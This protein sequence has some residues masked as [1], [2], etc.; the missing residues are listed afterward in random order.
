MTTKRG[1]RRTFTPP[2]GV[3]LA[4]FALIALWLFFPFLIREN[5]G[6]DALP[7]MVA[8][9]MA[10]EHPD[11]VYASE[12][13]DLYRL[14]PTFAARSCELA[15]PG[16]DCANLTVA[17]VAT[18]FALPLAV[19]LAPL[20]GDWGTFVLRLVGAAAL[21]GGMW[22][23][24]TRLAHR[25]RRAGH[26]MVVT[27]LLLTPFAMAPIALGQTSQLLFLSACLGI[28]RAE[29]RRGALA[30]ALWVATVAIKIFPAT[31]ALVLLW[32]RRWRFLVWSIAWT[33]ILA[34]LTLLVAP[35]SVWA[36]FV[37]ASTQLAGQT[38]WN[39]YNGSIDALVHN[40]ASPITDS[41]AGSLAL[42]L[43]RILGAG[44][45]AVWA[46][47][48]ADED[49]QWAYALLLTLLLVPLV[50]WHYLWIAVA[51]VA[52][53]LAGRVELDDRTLGVL[54]VLAAITIPI[55]ILTG[56]DGYVPVA[57]GLFLIAAVALVPVLVTGWSVRG[58]RRATATPDVT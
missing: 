46:A 47:R 56:R 11:D 53:A 55:S 13:G 20:G 38:N 7:Y 25:T 5:L 37:K 57:Q 21:S 40:L 48:H 42:L 39:L 18:P 2:D 44:A 33:A 23:L 54:P 3:R 9:Q 14:R 36:D 4:Y 31:L 52:V 41:Q 30:A 26:L 35:T 15:P 17:Y 49:T 12:N 28:T 1:T 19:A 32:Q 16:T 27:A 58:P 34:V 50:W 51:A 29:G 22:I 24:W 43:V 6:Q 10:S 45:L 8:G